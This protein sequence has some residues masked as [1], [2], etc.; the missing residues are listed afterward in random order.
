MARFCLSSRNFALMK[1]FLKSNGQRNR[2]AYKA[3][4]FTYVQVIKMPVTLQKI[5]KEI[6]NVKTELHLIRH[7]V[8]ED[9]ELSEEAKHKL[10]MARKAPLSEYI[11]HEEVLSAQ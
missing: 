9:Y 8:E 3:G 1:N 7:I 5:Y 6:E 11:S 2:K 4:V 10:E